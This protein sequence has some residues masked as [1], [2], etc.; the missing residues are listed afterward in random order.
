MIAERCA[1]AMRRLDEAGSSSSVHSRR[2]RLIAVG[3]TGVFAALL[4]RDLYLVTQW[5][6]D[7]LAIAIGGD[8]RAHMA[9][10]QRV[11]AGGP[12]YNL[13]QF[14]PYPIRGGDVLYPPLTLYLLIPISVLP[15]PLRAMAW[16]AI[17]L[18]LMVWSVVR[19]RPAWWA[20]PLIACCCW[21]WR[22]PSQ[23]LHGN[24]VMWAGAAVAL[25]TVFRWPAAFALVK[26]SVF[27]FAFVGVRSCGWW[28]T[29]VAM[30]IL[31]LP[32][33]QWT[34]QYPTVIANLRGLSPTYSL[35][36]YPFLAIPVIAMLASTRVAGTNLRTGRGGALVLPTGG[37][38]ATRS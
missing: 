23:I 37:V 7:Q 26:P 30:A 19:H 31:S 3:I 33:L 25:G 10:G 36:E 21:W 38:R 35:P 5:P 14:E 13:D 9:V 17:P 15:E 20:W 24:L 16:W 2:L 8:Y 27:P 34:L 32:V 6:A 28:L 1:A 12:Y 22:T 11:L 29:I 18:S 4:L